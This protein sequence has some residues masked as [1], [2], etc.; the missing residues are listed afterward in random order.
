M[1]RGALIVFIVMAALLSYER[2]LDLLK[3]PKSTFAPAKIVAKDHIT[4]SGMRKNINIYHVTFEFEN[5]YA[6]TL[7]VP[8]KVYGSV[9]EGTKGVLVY[10]YAWNGFIKRFR[11]FHID[12][13][14]A[15]IVN[16]DDKPNRK[17]KNNRIR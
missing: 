15:E 2:I 14:L 13:T 3:I 16:P 4:G 9:T 11:K 1:F 6:I 8:R 17:R 10:A 12:K 7:P 5:R